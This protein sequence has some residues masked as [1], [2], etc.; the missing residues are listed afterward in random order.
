MGSALRAGGRLE[1]AAAAFGQS[2]ALGGATTGESAVGAAGEGA[3]D[4]AAAAAA[5]SPAGGALGRDTAA[6]VHFNKGLT[7]RA[8]GDSASALADFERAQVAPHR[9][10]L[11][12][13][14]KL[15]SREATLVA[16]Q[17]HCRTKS[18]VQNMRA[19]LRDAMNRGAWHT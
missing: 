8:L 6:T 17:G 4:A 2:L 7:H 14:F 5:P 15:L 3:T 10:G 18:C 12:L 9:G 1:A 19:P 16:E 13:P 11:A